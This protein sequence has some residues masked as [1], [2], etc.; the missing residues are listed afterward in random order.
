MLAG[1]MAA[2]GVFSALTVL[3][4]ALL[5]FR[6]PSLRSWRPSSERVA[7]AFLRATPLSLTPSGKGRIAPS[8]RAAADTRM[9][10]WVSV[11]AA[12][13]GGLRAWRLPDAGAPRPQALN[14]CQGWVAGPKGLAAQAQCCSVWRQSPVEFTSQ[15]AS[16]TW[17]LAADTAQLV[18]PEPMLWVWVRLTRWR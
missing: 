13:L 5:T 12:G 11:S 6:V 7:S 14:R 15:S 18:A 17:W 8:L 16:M 10:V 3:G 2:V 9:R 1:C 4:A